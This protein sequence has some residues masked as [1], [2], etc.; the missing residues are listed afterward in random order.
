MIISPMPTPES[1][2]ERA[3][4]IKKEMARKLA[5]KAKYKYQLLKSKRKKK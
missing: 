4:R 1:R 3:E 2:Y 5:L